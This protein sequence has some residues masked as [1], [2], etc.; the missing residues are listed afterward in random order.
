MG[1]KEYNQHYK[2]SNKSNNQHFLKQ[3]PELLKVFT[4]SMKEMTEHNINDTVAARYL[5]ETE[6]LLKNKALN[7]VRKYFKDIRDGLL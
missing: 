1:L 6:P 5:I 7:T 2:D 4:G 3:H